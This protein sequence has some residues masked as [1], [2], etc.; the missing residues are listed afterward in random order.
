[1]REITKY[2]IKGELYE[3]ILF[4]D[5][6]EDWTC[7]GKNPTCDDCGCKIGEQHLAYCDVERCPRCGGQFLSCDCGIKY[8]IRAKDMKNL[9]QYIA[10]Q[11]VENKEY[12]LEIQ[13]ILKS[14]ADDKEQRRKNKKDPEM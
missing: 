9:P 1:M 7:D 14:I 3:P 10:E 6:D 2:L 8:S 11:K 5:E 13:R 12:E 4:G